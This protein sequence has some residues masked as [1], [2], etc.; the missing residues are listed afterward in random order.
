MHDTDGD[1]IGDNA[2]TNTGIYLSPT[3]TGT[4][5]EN[6]DSDGDGLSDSSETNTGSYASSVDTGTDP[7]NADTDGDGINDGDEYNAGSDPTNASDPASGE[8]VPGASNPYLAGMPNGSTCCSGDS[9]PAQSPTL[10]PDGGFIFTTA[11]TNG[12][13][14]ATWLATAL[15]GVFLD[16]NL[17]T[18]SPAPADLDFSPS[19]TGT[20]FTTLSPALQQAFFIGDGLT[21]TG[22]GD[23]QSFA[24][25]AG[26]TRLYL[27]TA[28]G[29]GWSNNTGSF[30][31]TISVLPE[32]VA[33]PTLSPQMLV[34]LGI[35]MAGAARF[36]IP[37]R[38]RGAG[39]EPRR[40]P[41]TRP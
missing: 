38:G 26:A 7:G 19:G 41:A 37:M 6:A 2:E 22:T 13:S 1:G 35:A 18:S 9:V 12:I 15:V 21:G 27:G 39:R 34:L 17:P 30:S 5:P 8:T 23:A 11:S 14:G 3:D 28:D 32:A 29:T 10:T 24:V 20:N 31:V 36:L 33:V 16:D 40:G 4:D 25:P